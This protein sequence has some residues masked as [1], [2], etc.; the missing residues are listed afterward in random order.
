VKLAS[1]WAEHCPA[2]YFALNLKQKELLVAIRGTA[3]FED[4]VTDLT[5]LPKVGNF[6]GQLHH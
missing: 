6:P 4:V 1:T 2:Y 3:Q 5:A